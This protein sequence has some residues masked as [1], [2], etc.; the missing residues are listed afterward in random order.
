MPDFCGYAL[1][2]DLER[3]VVPISKAASALAALF[4]R[5]RIERRPIVLTQKGYP[6]AVLLDIE[7]YTRLRELAEDQRQGENRVDG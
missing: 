7:L 5:T 2:V 1:D 3:G 4:K 6:S